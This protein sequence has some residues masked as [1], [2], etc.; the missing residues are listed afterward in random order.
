MCFRV[1]CRRTL[2]ADARQTKSAARF[3]KDAARTH[4]GSARRDPLERGLRTEG[5]AGKRLDHEIRE[6]LAHELRHGNSSLAYTRPDLHASAAPR[7][8]R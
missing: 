7:L 2:E 3:R 1:R 8:S 4:Q 5:T 6:R